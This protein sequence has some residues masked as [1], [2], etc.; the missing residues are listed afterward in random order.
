M[1]GKSIE[2]ARK[3]AESIRKILNFNYDCNT[4]I[5]EIQSDNFGVKPKSD[6]P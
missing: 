3:E 2:D 1:W 6:K 4:N 5:E